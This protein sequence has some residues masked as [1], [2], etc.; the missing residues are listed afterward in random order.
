MSKRTLGGRGTL[1]KK[2]NRIKFN[3]INPQRFE[4]SQFKFLSYLIPVAVIMG[5]PIIFIFINAFKPIDELFAYPPRF[6]VINP[7]LQ[8]FKTLFGLTADSSVP[9]TRYL[10]NSIA[11]TLLTVLGNVILAVCS[12]YVLSKKRFK[13]KKALFDINTTALMFVS[14]AVTIPRYFIIVYTGLQDNFLAHIIPL[15][16]SPTSVFLVKQ[17]IDQIPDALIEAVVIDGG[18]DYLIIRKIIMPLVSPAIAT[19]VIISFQ[20]A[21]NATEASTLYINNETL[22]NFAFYMNSLS[23]TG[24]VAGQ[25]VAAAS[26]LIMFLPNL[27]L[28]IICQSRVMNTMAHSGLK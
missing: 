12:G 4:I 28:F 20:T 8:N 9:V 18:S 1:M 3:G 6:Y 16:V 2:R 24:G 15:L 7:T 27:I 5:L 22:K 19:V 17:F 21:W 10:F 13:C 26:S 25:G 11:A 23:G 14:V